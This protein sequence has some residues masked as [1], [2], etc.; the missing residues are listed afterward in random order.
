MMNNNHKK[1]VIVDDSEMNRAIL[2]E[3]FKDEYPYIEADNGLEAWEII[4]S[5]P[6]DIAAVFLDLM[7]P[8]MSGIEV[9]KRMISYELMEQIPVFIVTAETHDDTLSQAFKMGV[10]DIIG[11][12]FNSSFIRRRLGNIIELYNHRRFLEET[13]QQ[14]LEKIEMQAREI[15]ETNTS[16]IETLS[17][18]IE[19]RD[20]ESGEHVKRIKWLTNRLLRELAKKHAEF[21]LSPAQIRIIS[22]AAV[23][24]DVGKIAISDKILNKP[25]PER[26]TE[27]EFNIMKLH[28]IKGCDILNNVEKLKKSEIYSYA[29]DI[30]RHHHERW[31][32]GGYPDG[33]KGN[34]I[35][36]WAQ[37]VSIVDVY[38]ALVTERVY[39]KAFPHQKALE[40][41]R[42]GEC[43]VFNPILLDC[44]EKAS[45][46][47]NEELYQATEQ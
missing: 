7:M 38:D 30:C 28:T 13:V 24:H 36:I 15:Q 45:E 31:D 42:N 20:C 18:A 27:E 34:E 8:V 29:Y 19:S 21:N 12:P 17:T 32:G 37:T 3:A 40:M 9:L 14:Q 44:F 10:V 47:I 6:S 23:M 39:K 41:I 2:V 4:S 22:D 25:G 16:I 46:S 1:L 5:S 26:L 11:K 35:S 33:L 43:G